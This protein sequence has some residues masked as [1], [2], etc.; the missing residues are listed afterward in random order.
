MLRKCNLIVSGIKGMSW[1]LFSGIYFVVIK[2]W[3][4]LGEVCGFGK[5]R[6]KV[7]FGECVSVKLFY[8]L[9]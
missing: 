8:L 9:Y 2:K 6:G 3:R 7:V 4:M 1:L 5:R